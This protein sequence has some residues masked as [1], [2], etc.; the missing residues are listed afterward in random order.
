M[1]PPKLYLLTN[2]DDITTLLDK[3]ERAFDTGAIS[4]LQIRRHATAQQYDLIT[5]YQETELLVSLADRY[6]VGVVVHDDLELACHFGTGLHL[7]QRDSNIKIV[8]ELLGKDVMIGKSCYGD[9]AVYKE[10]KKSG[11]NYGS[12]GTVFASLTTPKA[13]LISPSTLQKASQIDFSLCVVG[14]ITLDNAIELRH[15]LLGQKLDY[16]AITTDIMGHSADT[17][18]IKCRA[19]H[20]LLKNWHS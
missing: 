11:A 14:G 13:K 16:I 12:M 1:N 19:W 3:L 9:L 7:S 8:R 17:I 15:T 18:G 5:S 6:G 20:R 4:L 2:D 10:A